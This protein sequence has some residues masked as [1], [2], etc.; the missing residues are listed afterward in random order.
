MKRFVFMC[1]AVLISLSLIACGAPSS[2][3]IPMEGE[4]TPTL[5]S[6]K[7][8][9]DPDTPSVPTPDDP[10]PDDPTPDD[11]TPDDPTP[12]DPTPD[13]P[14]EPSEKRLTFLAAGDNIIHEAVFTDAMQQANILVS[15]GSYSGKYYFQGMYKGVAPLIA[16]ADLAFVNHETPVAGDDFG[17]TGYPLFNAPEAIGDALIEVGFDIVNLANNHMLDMDKKGTGLYNTIRYWNEKNIFQIGGYLNQDDYNT[18]RV[19]EKN[20]IKI[21]FLSYTTLINNGCT[22][23]PDSPDLVIPY[24]DKAVMAAHVASAK[25]VADL[26]MVSMHW[27][28]ENSSSVSDS[29]RDY[30]EYLASLGVDVVLGHHSH[31][32]QPVEWVE[33]QDGHRMLCY[34]SL[35]NFLSTQHPIKNLVGIFASFEIVLTPEGVLKIENAAAIPHMTWYSTERDELSVKLFSDVTEVDILSHGSQLRLSE[36]GGTFTLYDVQA[37]VKASLDEEFLV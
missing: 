4:P 3:F 14:P 21:A 7:P 18:V 29:Q 9:T 5:P 30:A 19:I 16:A 8:V 10:T 37:I 33:G 17:I 26:V 20:G 25:E 28:N 23:H 1:I 34:F 11:P 24:A 36:N 2:S 15:G 32:I 22:L 27:G 12:D 6:D 13:I 31:T 35:G